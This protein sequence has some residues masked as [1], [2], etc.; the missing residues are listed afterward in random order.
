MFGSAI[1]VFREAFETALIIGI[2][3]A[4]NTVPG[5]GALGRFLHARVGYAAMPSGIEVVFCT[6]MLILVLSGMRRFRVR[7]P[8]PVTS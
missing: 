8:S 1:I 3:A 4:A 6:A 5:G 7:P 2:V